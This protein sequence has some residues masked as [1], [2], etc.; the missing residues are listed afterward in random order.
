MHEMVQT[1]IRHYSFLVVVLAHVATMGFFACAG[2]LQLCKT[3]ESFMNANLA[4]W[5][6]MG[7]SADVLSMELGSELQTEAWTTLSTAP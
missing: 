7:D 5:Q 2:A 3:I 6:A 1:R 4:Q